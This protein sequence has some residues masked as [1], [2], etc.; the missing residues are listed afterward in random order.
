M[1]TEELDRILQV[2][3][4]PVRR[5]II[6]RLS[7]EPA[8]ALQLSKELGLGQSLVA[9]HLGII[10]EAGLVT[11]VPEESG[12]GPKRRRYYLARG[13][14]ITMDLGPNLFIE[15]GT[16][17]E[18]RPKGRQ[19]EAATRLRRRVQD[20]TEQ[21]DDARRLSVLSE[22]LSDLDE[23]MEEIEEERTELLEVRNLAM[24]EAARVASKFEE[25]DKRRVLFHILDE[26]DREVD[27][28]SEALNL[29]EFSVRSILDELQDYLE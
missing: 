22:V 13:I 17:F 10:E 25:L 18:A 8:Y 24:R 5:R 16:A 6:K 21:E 26:H 29:R 3:E 4:N 23:R 14:S 1:E 15:R 2:V 19:S 12:S 9:K 20:A 7:Q 28:I 11:S 27:R